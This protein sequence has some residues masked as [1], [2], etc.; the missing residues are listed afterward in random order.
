MRRWESEK[1]R[2]EDVTIKEEKRENEKEGRRVEQDQDEGR[3]VGGKQNK[4]M[5][6]LSTMDIEGVWLCM[7]P[8]QQTASLP[9]IKTRKNTMFLL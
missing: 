5:S 7:A 9:R 4:K 3:G 8:I 2:R 6:S 1:R